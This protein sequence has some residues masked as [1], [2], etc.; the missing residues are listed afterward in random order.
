MPSGAAARTDGGYD[1]SAGNDDDF[2]I[3]TASAHRTAVKA[4]A[5]TAFDLDDVVGRAPAA[6]PAQHYPKA[7]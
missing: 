5:A 7:P 4:E 2:A 3:R 1:N 6:T